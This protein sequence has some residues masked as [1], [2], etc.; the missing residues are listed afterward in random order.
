M[1]MR[2]GWIEYRVLTVTAAAAAAVQLTGVMCHLLN[3]ID[4]SLLLSVYL[5][6]SSDSRDV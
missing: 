2:V 1:R 3:A 4:Q 5:L 6:I